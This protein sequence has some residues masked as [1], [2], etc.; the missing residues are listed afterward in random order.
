MKLLRLV[1]AVLLAASGCAAPG[2]AA[3]NGSSAASYAPGDLVLRVRTGGGFAPLSAA[4]TQLPEISVY[5]DGRVVTIGPVPGLYPGPALPNIQVRRISAADVRRLAQRGLA[6]GVGRGEDMG[7]PNV[8][9]A[10]TTHITVRTATGAATTD[11]PAMG[12]DSG[13]EG[14][15]ADQRAARGRMQQYVAELRDLPETLGRKSVGEA[16][17]YEPA[18]I[19]AVAT[20]WRP[21]ADGLPS[22]PPAIEWP[23]ASALPGDPVPNRPGVNCL[24][25]EASPVLSAAASANARTP[26]LSGGTRWA[27][28][29]RPLLPDESGCADLGR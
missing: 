18:R 20:P 23:S 14:L 22:D 28:A 21:S 29:L 19:A 16:A 25:V 9:D 6:A 11:V 27:V 17:P 2:S 10:P 15:T 3:E 7:V 12:I 13:G 8:A 24:A 4:V 26:W 1:P 5:G